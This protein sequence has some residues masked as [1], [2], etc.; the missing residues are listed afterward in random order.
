M[1]VLSEIG[2]HKIVAILRGYSVDDTLKILKAL[3]YGGIRLAEVTLNT[4][5]ALECIEKASKMDAPGFCIGAGTVL[6]AQQAQQAVEAGAQFI[7]SP[8]LDVATIK[9]TK[10]LG[11]ISIP[12]AFTPTEVQ[13]A[14]QAGADIVK[15]FPS[16]LGPGYIKDLLGPLDQVKVMPT[17]GVNS[18]NI[19]AYLKAGAFAF[20]VAGELL[21]SENTGEQRLQDISNNA[22]RMT[23][24]MKE[25][26]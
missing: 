3:Y 4:P 11:A 7:I 23:G 22:R 24:L 6:N 19:E 13:A 2:K 18:G 21:K 25:F 20:G 14:H 9:K 10:E 5:N 12:G 1:D 17:G 8:G 26:S 16:V 15:I